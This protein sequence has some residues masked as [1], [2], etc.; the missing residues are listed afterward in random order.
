[1]TT[2]LLSLVLGCSL[3]AGFAYGQS[4]ATSGQITGRVVDASNAVLPGVT[5]RISNAATGF[6]R[7]TLTNN[8]GA[9]TA[10]L[11]PTGTY[12]VTAEL[13]GFRTA[14]A[15]NVSVTVGSNVTFMIVEP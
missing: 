15:S 3:V 11:L 2:R 14:K 4:Q 8:E 9:Y 10:P 7:D 5:V 12:D 1:M 6:S 13:Q